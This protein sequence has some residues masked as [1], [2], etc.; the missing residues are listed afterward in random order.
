MEK[1]KTLLLKE[2]SVE[3]KQRL[4]QGINVNDMG[5]EYGPGVVPKI[6]KSSFFK[7][8]YVNATKQH[9]YSYMPAHTHSFIEFNYQFS[10]QSFQQLN[11]RDYLLKP[12][13]LL[14]MD[15]SLIQRYGYMGHDDLLVNVLLDIDSLPTGFIEDI[16]PAAGFGRFLYNAL[17]KRAN[18][19]NYLVYDLNDDQNTIDIWEELMYYLLT[20]A[21][22]YETRGLLMK[23]ALSCLPTPKVTNIH[24]MNRHD[25]P[26][27]EVMDYISN[28]FVD[29][30]LADVSEQF[31]YNKNYLGNKIKQNTGMSFGELLDRKRLLAA[32]GLLLDTDQSI[33]KIAERLGYRNTSSL[34]RLFKNK[35]QVTPTE[36][37]NQ[38]QG[39]VN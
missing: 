32:E 38:H 24:V 16:K 26:I 11:G 14:V 35:L 21:Q 36:F 28:H 10:G 13:E 17:N 25:D 8:S 12:G 31:G 27:N 4:N 7:H 18:H 1:L 2:D 34:F 37:R 15:Q 20:K 30:S 19:D 6:P 3:T 23:A 29:T 39:E 22:P 9:R 33:S 5:L